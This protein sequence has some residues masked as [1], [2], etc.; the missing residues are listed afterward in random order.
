MTQ[1]FQL[2]ASQTPFAATPRPSASRSLA[3]TVTALFKEDKVVLIAGTTAAL[4][5]AVAVVLSVVGYGAPNLVSLGDRL[6]PPVGWGGSIDHLLGTDALG[7][8]VLTRIM[9]GISNSLLIGVGVVALA[10]SVGTTLGLA[11]G[12]RGGW[13]DSVVMRLVDMQFAFPGL[14]LVIVVLGVL[15]PSITTIVIVVAVY[16]WMI[17]ARLVRGNVLQLREQLYVGAAEMIGCTPA[18]VMRRHLMPNLVPPLLTQA[19]LELARVM[20]VEA[21]LSYLGLGLQPPAVSLGLMVAENQEYL[22]DG[23]WTVLFPGLTLAM[24]VLSIN[25]VTSWLR[26]RTDPQQRPAGSLAS[27]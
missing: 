7:R 3:A 21:S 17:Y 9:Y 27:R 4:L 24:L 1:G 12:Y 26:V 11:A 5:V 20:L 8:D 2:S 19:M 13:V 15:G 25:L 6:L 16:G 14:L 18:R 22:R 23:W 10:G